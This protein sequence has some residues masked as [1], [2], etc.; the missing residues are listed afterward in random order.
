MAIWTD[1]SAVP[2]V[3]MSIPT[4]VTLRL[5]PCLNTWGKTCWKGFL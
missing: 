3:I 1:T 2:Y 4:E 5:A